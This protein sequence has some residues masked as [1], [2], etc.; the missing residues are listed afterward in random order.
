MPE[1]SIVSPRPLRGL[2][3]KTVICVPFDPVPDVLGARVRSRSLSVIKMGASVLYKLPGHAVLTG[4]LGA[5][6]TVL[7]LE[8]LAASGIARIVILSFCGALAPWL[9]VGQTVIPTAAL[10][11]EGTS[12]HYFRRRKWFAAS[13]ELG[14]ELERRLEA[15]SVPF[16]RVRIVSTDAPF[17]ETQRWLAVM[18]R[19]GT[20]AVDME[21]SA[22][23]A[24]AEYRGLEAAAVMVVSD[25][26]SSGEWVRPRRGGVFAE[27]AAAAFL[28]FL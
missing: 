14:R 3:R 5:P 2:D 15:S 16:R 12:P 23:F 28:P 13:S 27:A 22:I 10:S 7:A 21:L 24:V 1:A 4:C 17:R 9:R 26:L 20:A 11:D 25:E 19:K 18:R 6:A 8:R